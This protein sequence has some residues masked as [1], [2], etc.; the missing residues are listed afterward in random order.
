M[1][2]ILPTDPSQPMTVAPAPPPGAYESVQ[3]NPAAFGATIGAA[4]ERLGATLGQAGDQQAQVAL[5]YQKEYNEAAVDQ[6]NTTFAS[7]ARDQAGNFRTLR[8]KDALDARQGTLD[9]IEQLR[10][11]ARAGLANP[12]QQR[13]FD[14]ISRREQQRYLD[15]VSF[16]AFQEG[17]V[18]QGDVAVGAINN[19]INNSALYWNDNNAFAQSLGKIQVQAGKLLQLKGI[20]PASDAGKA[21]IT[22]YTSEAWSAR[23]RSVMAQDPDT[24][25]ALF[26]ANADYLDAAHRSVLDQQITQHQYMSSMRADMEERRAEMTAAREQATTQAG[27]LASYTGDIL[28]GKSVTPGQIADA[29]RT[30]QLA[31][32]AAEFLLSLQRRPLGPVEDRPNAVVSLHQLLNDEYAT[33]DDKMQAIT[34]ASRAG[35]ITAATAGSLVDAA[36]KRDT[37]GENQVAKE[38]RGA[39]L[40]AAGVPDGLVNLNKDEAARKAAVEI[41]WT[42]RVTRGHEDPLAVRDDLVRRYQP[43]GT[44]PLTWPQ[45]HYGLIHSTQ[46]AQAVWAATRAAHDRGELSEAQFHAEAANINRFAGFYKQQDAAR[47]AAAQAAAQR[48]AQRSG[49]HAQLKGVVGSPEGGS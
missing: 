35:V 15:E 20:D 28:S 3:A 10:Q 12:Q 21:A 42:N 6:Q 22:H 34:A 46:D 18:W 9:Q 27:N 17:K 8:G 36:Y 40:A 29:V 31:P 26:D 33:V 43:S 44:A 11:S 37:T 14:Y 4:G 45:P 13:M 7:G 32:H 41:E 16:H 23:I 25:R 1:P 5:M 39:A 38:A 47:A 48:N 19:E 24:A 2:T 49:P 30:Q